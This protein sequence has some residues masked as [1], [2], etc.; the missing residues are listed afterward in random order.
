[1]TPDGAPSVALVLAKIKIGVVSM[2]KVQVGDCGISLVYHY[3]RLKEKRPGR[4]SEN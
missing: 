2:I 1:L 4:L 3:G